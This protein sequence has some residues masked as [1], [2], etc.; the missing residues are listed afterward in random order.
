M[1]TRHA[2]GILGLL[3]VVPLPLLGAGPRA[4]GPASGVAER[5]SA[6][7]PSE[8]AA[9]G[10]TKAAPL[11]AGH[12]SEHEVEALPDRG[13]FIAP[14]AAR[15]ANERDDP[16]RPVERGGAL[17]SKTAPILAGFQALSDEGTSPPDPIVAAGPDHV[18]V[19]VNSSWAVYT[20]TGTKLF[21]TTAFGWFLPQ[22]KQAPNGALLPYDPQ[23]AYDHFR[24]R[25]ILLYSATDTT[26]ES[27]LLLSVS[28]SSDPTA[29]WY[30][31][32]LRGDV[33]GSTPSG[34][35]SDFPALGFDDT[36]IY[37]ATNQYRYADTEFDY[38]R[39]RVLEKDALY[40]GN[41]NPVWT[42]LWALEDP[43]STGTRVHS[44]R[45]ATTFGGPP[46]EYLVSNSPFTTRTFVTLWS[47]AGAGTGSPSLSAVDVPVTATLAPPGANQ[48]GGSPGT[49][50]CPT[51]C[52]IN[53]GS[54]GVTSAVYRNGDV[55]LSDTVA[56]HGGITSRA[57]YARIRAA[58][59]AAVEEEAFGSEGCWYYYPS[60]AV[61][62]GD[63][64]TMV[65]GRSCL[66][67]YAGVGL[68]SRTLADPALEPSTI[69]KDGDA[70]YV[71]AIGNTELV[72]RW[73]DFFGAAADPA[74]PG[75]VWVIGEY[76]GP[77]NEWRT[78]V[79]ETS[80]DL[81]A[82]SCVP[83]PSTLCFGNGRFRAAA[84]WQ[85]SEGSSGAGM[86]APISE[87][88]GY[89]WF[90]DPAN[91]EIVAKVLDGCGVNG[92]RWVFAGG[93]TNLQVTLTVT[94]TQTGARA[95]HSNTLGAPFTPIQDT[96]ALPC[97]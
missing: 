73:G 54:G 75:R 3:T 37:V 19:A 1:V 84:S 67:E 64:L 94:D 21:E 53:T 31:W 7:R 17:H 92:H 18:V 72:N 33:N 26:S 4:S 2:V 65:F 48:K 12:R 69:V 35:F 34:N 87:D 91:I 61:D 86:A 9:S 51:P 93:L 52:L 59:G 57:R 32:I 49:A 68:T 42:D 24:S 10:R 39:V 44:V 14:R 47:L 46:V 22:L 29:P 20:K 79:G 5:F 95:V 78:W 81:A 60:V 38:A 23:V 50:G 58:S 85:K 43:A 83:D 77:R 70:T 96:A 55:W 15:G 80:A 41:P 27:F 88:T 30:S 11:Q 13:N 40:A 66:D 82:G 8:L 74:D 28:S 62:A 63:N 90:F 36:A 6:T 89:F 76:A 56:D 97:P 16:A 71:H 25:W 45:P